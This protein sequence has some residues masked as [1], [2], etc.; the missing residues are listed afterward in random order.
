MEAVII[1]AKTVVH[2][3]GIPVQL[4]VDTIVEAAHENMALLTGY[5]YAFLA[6]Q[7]GVA[8]VM[9]AEPR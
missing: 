4:A 8:P 5:H 2:V 3:G 1:P 9:K 7:P 6:E